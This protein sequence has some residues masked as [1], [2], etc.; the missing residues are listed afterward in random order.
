MS[1]RAIALGTLG[2][3]TGGLGRAVCLGT[4]GRVSLATVED[5]GAG[6]PSMFMPLQDQRAPK[7]QPARAPALDAEDEEMLSIIIVSQLYGLFDN[8]GTD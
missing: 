5:G 4:I 8:G 6:F 2:M 1:G 7:K 3:I